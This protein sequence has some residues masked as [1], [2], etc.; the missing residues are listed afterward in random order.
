VTTA[1]AVELRVY[2]CMSLM[3]LMI[4]VMPIGMLLDVVPMILMMLIF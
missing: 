1:V 3:R 4:D 2:V